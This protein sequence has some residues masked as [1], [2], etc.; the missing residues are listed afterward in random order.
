MSGVR[1]SPSSEGPSRQSR[2]PLAGVRGETIAAL[3]LRLKGYRVLARRY[4]AAGGEI[5]LIA[6]RG[7]VVAFVEVK[8]RSLIADAEV[9]ITADK[10]RRIS[11]AVRHWLGR[12]G[13]AVGRTLRCDAI[14]V[15][16]RALPR[17][18]EDVATLTLD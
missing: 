3:L 15:G 2:S 16:R 14:F 11:R 10:R 4:R 12:N 8:A 6:V 18:V 7:S 1:A 5:D 13:W 17:H 9:A